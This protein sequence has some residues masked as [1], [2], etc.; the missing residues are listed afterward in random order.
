MDTFALRAP[1]AHVALELSKPPPA[2]QRVAAMPMARA[3]ADMCMDI[4]VVMATDTRLESK[5]VSNHIR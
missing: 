4:M 2:P 1:R 5:C 3:E